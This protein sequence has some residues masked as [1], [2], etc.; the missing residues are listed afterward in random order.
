ML[1]SHLLYCVPRKAGRSR[2]RVVMPCAHREGLHG[3][4]SDVTYAVTLARQR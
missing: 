2:E 3:A 1:G 4:N